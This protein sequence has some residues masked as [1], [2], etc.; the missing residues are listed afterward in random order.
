MEMIPGLLCHV[1]P[2]RPQQ[3]PRC[4]HSFRLLD[5]VQP[6]EDPSQHLAHAYRLPGAVPSVNS[7]DQQVHECWRAGKQN[8]S[9]DNAGELVAKSVPKTML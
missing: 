8:C 4:Q 3:C 2:V 9:E 7:E 6:L 5:L 1:R